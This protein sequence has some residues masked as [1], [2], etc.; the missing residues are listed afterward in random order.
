MFS[1][2][3]LYP[4]HHWGAYSAFSGPLAAICH[5]I[6]TL[7]VYD[8]VLEKSAGVL[9]TPGISCNQESRNPVFCFNFAAVFILDFNS[10]IIRFSKEVKA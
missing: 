9:Q 5:Y 10:L 2:L 6:Y 7:L 4:G 3:G 1:L 8:K